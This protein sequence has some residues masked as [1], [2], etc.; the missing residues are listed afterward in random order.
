MHR[1]VAAQSPRALVTGGA[2]FIGS[3][4]AERLLS[5]GR[6]VRVVDNLS[7]GLQSNIEV[8]ARTGEQP[9]AGAFE[10]LQGDL[11]DPRVCEAAVRAVDTVFHAAAIGSVPRSM[12]DPLGSHESN[13]NATLNLLEAARATGVRRFV[14]SSSSSVY[15][16]TDVLPKTESVEPLPRSPYAASKLAAEQYV[17][18]YAR[19]GLVEGNALRYF[20]V[21]GPRQDPNGLYAAVIP[22]LMRAAFTG[23][24]ATVFG[25][26]GQTRDFTYI[27]NVVHANLLAATLPAAR[28]SGS[29]VN[30]GAGERT[31]LLELIAL[32]ERISGRA[33]RV[34]HSPPR[35]GDVRDSQAGM[36]RAERLLGYAPNV[37]LE[38][39]LRRTW[40]WTFTQDGGSGDGGGDRAVPSAV[41]TLV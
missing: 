29:V 3:H 27:D 1:D 11:R 20:N 9:G 2:G 8:L 13:V 7:T 10:F 21:F 31:S 35:E 23:G 32:I 4:L 37:G 14:F 41:P 38:E 15:G 26:G 34:Q 39:G 40:Q 30:C 12:R 5:E 16:D 6:A 22:L 25:D 36:E 24:T 28:V 19:A 33:L 18:A 17:L